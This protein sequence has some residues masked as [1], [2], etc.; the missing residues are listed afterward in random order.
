[1]IL[2]SPKDPHLLIMSTYQFGE[3]YKRLDHKTVKGTPWS[4]AR[5]VEGGW[6]TV[7][8]PTHLLLEVSHHDMLMTSFLLRHTEP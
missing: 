6:R 2:M 5:G 8:E 3:I 7:R 4:D 1:M